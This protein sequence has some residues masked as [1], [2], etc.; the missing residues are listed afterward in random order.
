ML[1]SQTCQRSAKPRI[2]NWNKQHWMRLAPTVEA[3]T[4]GSELGKSWIC[5]MLCATRFSRVCQSCSRSRNRHVH[6]RHYFAAIDSKLW[7]F[8]SPEGRQ[9]MSCVRFPFLFKGL[10]QW[11]CQVDPRILDWRHPGIFSAAPVMPRF[12]YDDGVTGASARLQV[13]LAEN[14][15]VKA[16]E[17][18]HG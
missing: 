17:Q 18:S 8:A 11:R 2:F 9:A 4:E 6:V 1:R 10:S 12:L 14:R 3:E 13:S 15:P 7:G 5:S 16:P